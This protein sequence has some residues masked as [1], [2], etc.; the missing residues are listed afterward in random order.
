VVRAREAGR[1]RAL[2]SKLKFLR[3]L[4]AI[5]PLA[6]GGYQIDLDGPFSLFQSV[7]RYGLQL[8]LALPTITACDAWQIEA[9]VLWGRDRKPLHFRW[10]GQAP[11][12]AA[13]DAPPVLADE[14]AALLTA[15]AALNGPWRAQAST[16]IFNLP[17]IGLCVPDLEFRH[18]QTG[19]R[20]YLEVMGFWSREAVWRRVDLVKAGLPQPIL[21]AVGKQLRV[22]E[23]ALD[24]ELPGALYVYARTM[25]AKT[26]I[27]RIAALAR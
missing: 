27:Q 5:T 15:V 19:A 14:V 24:G 23:A 21:F 10:A 8:G 18:R 3:L 2:F 25:N 20:A 6:R 17:G 13:A 1:Y 22:S 7:T 4:H 11:D 9:D 26:V 16:E 12:G